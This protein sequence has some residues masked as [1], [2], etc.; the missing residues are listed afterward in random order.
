M[1]FCDCPMHSGRIKHLIDSGFSSSDNVPTQSFPLKGKISFR[2]WNFPGQSLSLTVTFLCSN[3]NLS[4]SRLSNL[5]QND[6]TDSLLTHW[7]RTSLRKILEGV[8]IG[9]N[10]KGVT[11]RDI[12][13]GALFLFVSGARMSINGS[14]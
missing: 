14:F 1:T 10:R 4:Y 3:Q 6:K 8:K 11:I 5:K 12:M 2:G 7:L 9:L 13:A